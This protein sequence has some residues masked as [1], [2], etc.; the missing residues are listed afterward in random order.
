MTEEIRPLSE[1]RNFTAFLEQHLNKKVLEYTLKP[2]TKPG[3]NFGAIV[4]SVDVKAVDNSDSDEVS[5]FIRSKF[6][7]IFYISLVLQPENINLVVKTPVTSPYLAELFKPAI[8]FVKEVRFYSDI[9]PAV[10]QFE[11]ASNVPEIE[12]LDAFIQCLGWRISLDPSRLHINWLQPLNKKEIL[13]K[14]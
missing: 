8:S 2:L 7:I 9:I 12:R 13:L 4:K 5:S 1:I 14:T 6:G 11:Q 3:D 10:E